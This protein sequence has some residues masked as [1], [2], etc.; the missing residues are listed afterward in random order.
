MCSTD[1]WSNVEM[2]KA[3]YMYKHRKQITRILSNLFCG[4]CIFCVNLVVL[5]IISV[6][7]ICRLIVV[8]DF[9]IGWQFEIYS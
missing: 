4:T 3:K 9:N 5:S 8:G 7:P 1:T 6:I 2:I